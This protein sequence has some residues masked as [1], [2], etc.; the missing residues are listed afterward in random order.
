MDQL[1]VEVKKGGK[2]HW[3]YSSRGHAETAY[4]GM[5]PSAKNAQWIVYNKRNQLKELSKKNQPGANEQLF[6]GLSHT[7]IEYSAR[8]QKGLAKLKSISN[9]FDKI[10]VACPVAPDGVQYHE[11]QF[12]LAGCQVYGINGALALL[13]QAS[14]KKCYTNALDAAQA[15]FWKPATIWAAWDKVL[16]SSGLIEEG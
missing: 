9:P 15:A 11:W 12:F 16:A 14:V 1:L 8:P 6:G 5:K 7:R 13:P 4:L 3:Y 2:S 10:S